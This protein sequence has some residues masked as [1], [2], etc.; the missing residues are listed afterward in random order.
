MKADHNTDN[1]VRSLTPSHNS[2]MACTDAMEN[3]RQIPF[4]SDILR[5]DGFGREALCLKYLI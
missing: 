3:M 2:G 1:E 5:E 4:T